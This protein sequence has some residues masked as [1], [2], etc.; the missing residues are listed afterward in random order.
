MCFPDSGLLDFIKYKVKLIKEHNINEFKEE[1]NKE[2]KQ[3]KLF[4]RQKRTEKMKRNN[5]VL[6]LFWAYESCVGTAS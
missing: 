1:E 2:T 3:K 5:D 6:L 4:E